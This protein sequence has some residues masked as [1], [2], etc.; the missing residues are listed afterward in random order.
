MR[1]IP[2]PHPGETIKEDFLIPL[3]MSVSALA[4]ELGVST[5]RLNEI[6][7]GRR[8]ITADT[9]LR[10][11]RY[12]NM[13]PDFW[14]GLQSIYELRTAEQASGKDINKT[15]KPRPMAA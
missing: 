8:G 12:F 6:V 15:V 13:S 5:V 2:P 3:N 7:L 14:M 9:A 1:T 11:A 4:R 10:L